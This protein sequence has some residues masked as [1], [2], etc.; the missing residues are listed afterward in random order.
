[1]KRLNPEA[2]FSIVEIIIVTVV[3]STLF[4]GIANAFNNV[5]QTYALTRQLNEMYAVL[6]SCPEIDRALQYDSISGTTNCFPNNV[7]RGEGLGGATITYTPTLTVT[8]TSDLGLFDPLRNVPDSKVI[9]ISV[10]NPVNNAQP[11]EIRL[12]VARNGIGQQ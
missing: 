11:W 9:D 5:S 2:G 6:S 3:I 8:P 1:M 10:S 12:L 4:I 7:F